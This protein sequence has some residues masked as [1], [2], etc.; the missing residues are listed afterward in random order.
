MTILR[1]LLLCIILCVTPLWTYAQGAQQYNRA[2]PT[3]RGL[4][5]WY[6]ARPGFTGGPK[7]Y[8]ATGRYHGALTSSVWGVSSRAGGRYEL[9]LDGT[10]ST[11]NLGNIILTGGNYTIAVWL[12]SPF[13]GTGYLFDAEYSNGATRFIVSLNG[14]ALG[15]PS[16]GVQV[17]IN[18][19]GAPV[20]AA[21]IFPVDTWCHLTLTMSVSANLLTAYLNGQVVGTTGFAD[22]FGT[23]G[24]SHFVVGSRHSQGSEFWRGTVDD[25]RLYTTKYSAG[26]VQALYQ[27]TAQ[28]N[29]F[30]VANL[31]GRSIS[32][33]TGTFFHLFK[34]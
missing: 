18:G 24:A 17:E 8:D 22:P 10:S 27:Q 7:W 6:L 31:V 21:N 20:T 29:T 15:G 23:S 13:N 12:K 28:P 11:V 33:P 2:D 30:T 1:Y 25:I 32:V 26:E 9:R 16:R 5:A 3:V 14:G 19:A 4:V 34:K